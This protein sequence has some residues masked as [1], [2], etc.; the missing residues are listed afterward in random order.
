MN[1]INCSNKITS[2]QIR[3]TVAFWAQNSF[4]HIS[5]L[6]ASVKGTTAVLNPAFIKELESLYRDFK[7]IY[8][9]YTE[10]ISRLPQRPD[11]L[12][13]TNKKFVNLLERIKFE[14][15]SGY[16][17]LQQS[18]FH[19]IYEGK[20]INAVF[21][22]PCS[23][24]NLLISTSFQPFSSNERLCIY[25]QMYFWSIIGAMH[26]SLLMDSNAFYNSING[27]SREYLTEITNNFG[28]LNFALSSLKRPLQ[29]KPL[30]EL[31]E[32]FCELNTAFL[33][34]LLA[35]KAGNIKIYSSTSAV[36]LPNSFYAK[37]EHMIKEH[38]LVNELNI[39]IKKRLI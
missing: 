15:F 1:F 17:M 22:L 39:N 31:F 37:A 35:A 5:S 6:L 13:R 3:K 34:F 11:A 30:A 21:G 12:L 18:L 4:Q 28:K 14:G 29:K 26:P 36:R 10:G 23:I 24:S 27:Y 7:N 38:T 8:S 19:Y 2:E 20:Y 16:P 33:D 25:N 32:F 9:A